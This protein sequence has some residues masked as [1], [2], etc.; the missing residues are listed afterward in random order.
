M[1]HNFW[2]DGTT[3]YLSGYRD[4]KLKAVRKFTEVLVLVKVLHPM[5]NVEQ[6]HQWNTATYNNLQ[7]ERK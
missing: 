5:R 1:H 3:M 6:T 7:A 4:G 2:I